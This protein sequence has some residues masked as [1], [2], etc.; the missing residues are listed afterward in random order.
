VSVRAATFVGDLDDASLATL[1]AAGVRRRFGARTTVMHEGD[2]GN[3][4]YVVLAGKLKASSSQADGREQ[5]LSVHGP[6]DVVGLFGVIDGEVRSASVTTFDRSEL[7]FV[8]REKWFELF[9]EDP[10]IGIA[11]MRQL[12]RDFRAANRRQLSLG[13]LDTTGRVARQLAE[14]SEVFGEPVDGGTEIAIPVTHQDLA[15]WV[16]AS[17]EGAGRAVAMLE[18]LG[19]LVNPRRGCFVVRDVQALATFG[20]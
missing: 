10:S 19:H 13:S 12:A 6:G 17:R 9:V 2:D 3:G 15:N 18:Q 4:A 16:G 14:L 5:L 7:L 11:V 8:A 20:D 1:T